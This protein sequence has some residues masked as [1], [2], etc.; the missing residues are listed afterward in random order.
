MDNLSLRPE[1]LVKP[2]RLSS[3]EI[4]KL[5][6]EAITEVFNAHA[7]S[8]GIY[9]EAWKVMLLRQIPTSESSTGHAPLPDL[10]SDFSVC[11]YPNFD[12]IDGTVGQAIINNR[13]SHIFVIADG[14]RASKPQGLTVLPNH[15]SGKENANNYPVLSR[16]IATYSFHG[17]RRIMSDRQVPDMLQAISFEKLLK[18][19]TE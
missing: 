18:R 6:V 16:S 12:E 15:L 7:R 17:T 5:R 14:K 19:E 9:L 1:L 11:L 4:V 8:V 3:S 2:D 13:A 10:G